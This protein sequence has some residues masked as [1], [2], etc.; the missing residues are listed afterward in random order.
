MHTG[1]VTEIV[2]GDTLFVTPGLED[3][4]EIRLVGIQA[5]KLPLGRKHFKIWPLANEAKQALADMTLGKITW[6]V[7]RW[8][9]DATAM[10]AGLR[11]YT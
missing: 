5:P 9:P 3:S 7:I 11:T 6:P 2:D 4:G 10:A 8:G 1:K